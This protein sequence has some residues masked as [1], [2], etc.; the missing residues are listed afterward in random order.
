[1]RIVGARKVRGRCAE[2]VREVRERCAG[3][4]RKVRGRCA[5]GDGD[6]KIQDFMLIRF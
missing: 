2:G 4:A 1:M 6:K 5:E 3:G